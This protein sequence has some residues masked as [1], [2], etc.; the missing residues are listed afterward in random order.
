[1]LSVDNKEAYVGLL[2]FHPSNS[3]MSHCSIV[4]QDGVSR[5]DREVPHTLLPVPKVNEYMPKG[6]GVVVDRIYSQNVII[7][8]VQY[9]TGNHS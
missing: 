8:T 9:T 7:Q 6:G 2:N 4:C 5:V 1:M 3:K